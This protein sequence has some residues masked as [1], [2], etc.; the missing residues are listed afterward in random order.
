MIG[1][2]FAHTAGSRSK[3]QRT[4]NQLWAAPTA[5]LGVTLVA[6]SLAGVGTLWERLQAPNPFQYRRQIVG[7]ALAMIAER[8]GRGFGLGTFPQVYP[9]YATFDAGAV[10]EHAHNDWLEWS[11]DGGLPFTFVSLLLAGTLIVPAIRSRW[12]IGL[13]AILLHALVDYPFAKFGLTTWIFAL[14]GMLQAQGERTPSPKAL[15]VQTQKK[16]IF[17]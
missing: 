17:L 9:G 6:A 1:L 16:E 4:R 7:S 14:A 11:I 13:L 3:S 12:G 10:V 2:V 15:T 8:P 5:F